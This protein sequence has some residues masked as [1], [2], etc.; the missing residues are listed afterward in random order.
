MEP[1]I[2]GEG[3]LNPPTEQHS[4]LDDGDILS[5]PFNRSW[6]SVENPTLD[7]LTYGMDFWQSLSGELVTIK[8]PR[9]VSKSNKYQ[10]FFIVGSWRTT[11][12]NSRGG[13]TMTDKGKTF[14]ISTGWQ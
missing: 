2:L 10:C 3:Q 13:L 5:L 4:S 12:D 7:P 14:P 6:I 11:G 8:S 1:L 9:A